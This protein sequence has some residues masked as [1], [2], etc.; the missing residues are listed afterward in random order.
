M[1]KDK[2]IFSFLDVFIIVGISS[3]VMCFLGASLIYKHLGGVNFSLIGEDADL[4]EFIGAYNDLVDNYYASLDKK[5]LIKG[6]I[7]GM[8]G[9]TGDPYTT[10]LNEGSASSLEDSLNGKYTGIGI[11]ITKKENGELEI[12]QVYEDSP[13]FKAG[14][15]KGDIIKK[16]DGE[17]VTDSESLTN[18][19]KN[20]KQVTLTVNRAGVDL[21]YQVGATSL[22]VPVVS[23]MTFIQNGKRI[24]YIRLTSFNSTSDIQVGEHLSKLEKGGVDALALDLRDNS[25]GYL[26]MAENIAEMFIEKGKTIYSLESKNGSE[27]VKDETNEKRTY[28]IAVIMN[29]GSASASEVLA[30]ALKYSYGAKLIGNKSYGKGKVQKKASLASGSAIKYTTDKWLVPNGECIDG[31]GLSPDIEVDFSNDSYIKD[32]IYTDTQV[33]RTIEDLAS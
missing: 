25:G 11:T 6:A 9:V 19:I 24:G 17:S 31:I 29:K 13:A 5:D 30:G 3:L 20:S 23:S 27:I 22:N 16:I 18:K 4:Q 33:M 12:Y 7:G 8:Y 1:D 26:Q 10:Y 21:S 32:N 2:K 28:P 14:L 15:Q